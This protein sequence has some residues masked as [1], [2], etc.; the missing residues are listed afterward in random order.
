MEDQSSPE[1][2]WSVKV[3]RS[4]MK[5][6]VIAEIGENHYGRWDICRAM[7]EEAV[8]NGATIAKF[9]TYTADQ[10]GKDHRAVCHDIL[11]FSARV[12]AT[13]GLRRRNR[14]TL[15]DPAPRVSRFC[16]SSPGIRA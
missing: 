13:C 3:Q 2:C 7:V 4:Q 9:Q 14:V 16:R 10:F 5:T 6:I 12:L 15:D 1:N 8:A 11:E